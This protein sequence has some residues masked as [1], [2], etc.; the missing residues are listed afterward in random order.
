MY[1]YDTISMAVILRDYIE[2]QYIDSEHKDLVD[3]A[4]CLYN[5]GW[6]MKDHLDKDSKELFDRYGEEFWKLVLKDA[7][8]IDSQLE[9]PIDRR[10]EELALDYNDYVSG[11]IDP[12][13]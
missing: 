3:I 8:A 10:L 9:S 2:P 12:K 7:G 5:N 1:R 13:E 6:F 11:A 4:D